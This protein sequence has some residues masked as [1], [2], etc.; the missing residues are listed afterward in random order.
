[1]ANLLFL[2]ML[3]PDLLKLNYVSEIHV[4]VWANFSFHK[5]II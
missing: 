3:Y 2:L 4:S 5:I 1:M